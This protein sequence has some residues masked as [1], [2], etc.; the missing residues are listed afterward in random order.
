MANKAIGA[1]ERSLLAMD[2]FEPW[3]KAAIVLLSTK[4]EHRLTYE[5]IADEVGVDV[6]T[7]YRFRQRKDV[8]KALG[9]YVMAQIV[10]HMPA[11]AAKQIEQAI[12]RGSVK[13]AEWLGKM[14]GLLVERRAVDANVTAEMSDVSAA[15]NDELHAELE[16]LRSKLGDHTG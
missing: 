12:T 11:V 14:S 3:Q 1:A 16:A 13:S 2:S 8:Q 10:D 5:Q 6:R 4:H 9:E 7:I 15:S